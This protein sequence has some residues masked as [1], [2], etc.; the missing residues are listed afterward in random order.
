MSND[1]FDKMATRWDEFRQT[2]FQESLRERALDRAAVEAGKSAAD[3]GAGT[4]FLT[5]G[6]LARGLSVIAVDSS[7]AMLQVMA[8][9]FAGQPVSFVAGDAV[10][11][12]IPDSTAD[13]AF[14]NMFLH[15]AESPPAVI[16]EIARILKPGGK[17]VITDMDEHNHTFLLLEQHDRWPGF[18]REDILSWFTE[19]GLS[20]VSVDCACDR[21]C[22]TSDCGTSTEFSVFLALG[23]KP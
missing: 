23:K 17:L 11:L 1:Y 4:G 15:H 19:A 14:A 20:D 7:L 3:I 12:D 16:R 9:K 22:A 13:Y 21:C 2:L 18:R 10:K 8:K 6:L 5:E